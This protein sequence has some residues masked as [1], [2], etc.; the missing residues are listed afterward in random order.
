MNAIKKSSLESTVATFFFTALYASVIAYQPYLVF[1]AL[2]LAF[3]LIILGLYERELTIQRIPFMLGLF[4]MWIPHFAFAVTR[5]Y[6]GYHE[7]LLYYTPV[8]L[9]IFTAL[10]LNNTHNTNKNSMC[11]AFIVSLPFIFSDYVYLIGGVISSGAAFKFEMYANQFT[12]NGVWSFN[13]LVVGACFF[14][15]SLAVSRDFERKDYLVYLSIII[16]LFLSLFFVSRLAF[17]SL[18]MALFLRSKNRTRFVLI[19]AV[20]SLI[21]FSYA[22]SVFDELLSRLLLLFSG[23][24]NRLSYTNDLSSCFNDL[25]SLIFGAP[26]C[27]RSVA[28]SDVDSVYVDL[29]YRTGLVSVSMFLTG[30]FL[31]CM[32][33]RALFLDRAVIFLFGLALYAY[34]SNLSKPEFL[35]PLLLLAAAELKHRHTRKVRV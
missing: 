22:Y 1:V 19:A 20:F 7:I 16:L 28:I 29:F 34:D 23:S 17:I 4:L 24:E 21:V 27:V 8:F 10:S 11:Y 18:V 30:L 26:V 32:W 14:A 13:R 5:S 31:V 9:V 25:Y 6:Y 35:S 3:V 12:G 2:P 15:L 33:S